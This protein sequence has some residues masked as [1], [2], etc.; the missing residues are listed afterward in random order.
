MDQIIR[1]EVES[2]EEIEYL[3]IVEDAAFIDERG[4]LLPIQLQWIG[5]QPFVELLGDSVESVG[6][7]R[8]GFYIVL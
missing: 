7:G 1:F 8:G 3:L 4:E 5:R 2:V 6:V